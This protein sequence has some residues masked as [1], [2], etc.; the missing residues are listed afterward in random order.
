MKPF[1]VNQKHEIV[2]C[3]MSPVISSWKYTTLKSE[4]F[5]F[6][7]VVL[8]FFRF[9]YIPTDACV[10]TALD[11]SLKSAKNATHILCLHVWQ[12]FHLLVLANV[13]S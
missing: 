10:T 13:Y 9:K 3:Y 5:F 1:N 8:E 6:L 11:G 12:I 4:V 2:L 7:T